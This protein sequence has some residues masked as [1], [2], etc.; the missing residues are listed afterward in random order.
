VQSDRS[1]KLT[2]IKNVWSS[3]SASLYD[4]C[5]N[6][7]WLN[8]NEDLAF[9]KRIGFTNVSKIKS[10]GKYLFKIKCK[11]GNKVRGGGNTTPPK[12]SWKPKYRMRNWT[13]SRNSNGG[14]ISSVSNSNGSDLNNSSSWFVFCLYV[15][16][17]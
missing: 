4:E 2:E 5:V 7:K 3:A 12:G 16:S 14:G 17:L 13:E 6:S 11:L 10:P 8:I 1:V 9:R 15:G